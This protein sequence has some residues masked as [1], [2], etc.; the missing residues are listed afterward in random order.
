MLCECVGSVCLLC[1]CRACV[2]CM[3]M[4]SVSVCVYLYVFLGVLISHIHAVCHQTA[5]MHEINKRCRDRVDVEWRA[6]DLLQTASSAL[7]RT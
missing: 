6:F 7:W 2:V 3:C 1:V 4:C 5:C